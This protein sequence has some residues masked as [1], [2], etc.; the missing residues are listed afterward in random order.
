MR[1]STRLAVLAVLGLLVIVS[2]PGVKAQGGKKLRIIQNAMAGDAVTIIDPAMNKVVGQIEGIEISN[3]VA[4]SPDGARIY[5]TGEVEKTLFVADAKTFKVEMKVPLSG[6]PSAVAVSK[7]GTRIFVGIQDVPVEALKQGVTGVDVVDAVSLRVIKNLPLDGA[8][9]HYV[10]MTRDGKYAMQTVN[11][12]AT[13]QDGLTL[14]FIDVKTLEV[15]KKITGEGTGGHRACDFVPNPDLSTKYVV[16]NQGQFSGFVV[17]DFNSGKVFKK[18]PNPNVKSGE[19]VRLRNVDSAQGSPSHGIAV[20]PDGKLVVVSDR[21]YNLIHAYS[22]PDFTHLYSVPVAPDP[23][24]FSFSPDGKMVYSSAAFSEMVSV[25][26]L[27]QRKE[28]ARIR[29]QNQPKRIM[30]AMLQ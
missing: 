28:V 15:A 20:S 26:D 30:T 19:I 22:A 8:K 12:G 10:F 23:F 21:W 29:V 1:I 13:P 11:G 3:G 5:A 27:A 25:V 7:D 16:C 18:V 24:W 17:Y 6:R 9:T 2:G 4:A 14:R